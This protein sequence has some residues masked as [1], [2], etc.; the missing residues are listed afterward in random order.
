MTDTLLSP[1]G[2]KCLVSLNFPLSFSFVT[3]GPQGYL[4][5]QPDRPYPNL[6]FAMFHTSSVVPGCQVV[7][8]RVCNW[9]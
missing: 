1:D 4:C 6:S 3:S 7:E 2:Q 8:G 9:H 5:N